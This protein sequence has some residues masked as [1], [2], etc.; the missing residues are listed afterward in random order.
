[1]S[2]PI[3][4]A[5]ERHRKAA[6]AFSASGAIEDE[7][8]RTIPQERR[9]SVAMEV[10]ADD[11]PRWQDYCRLFQATVTEMNNSAND[12]CEVRATSLAGVLALLDYLDGMGPRFEWSM[13]D[14][15]DFLDAFLPSL[16]ETLK[17]LA[18]R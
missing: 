4:A 1:M 15:D 11:D 6:D 10:N 16:A 5:I 9:T 17:G 2:D 14:A 8:S 13:P 18:P 7:L 12:L 3:Y